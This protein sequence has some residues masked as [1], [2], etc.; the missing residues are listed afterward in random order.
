MRLV[1]NWPII[2]DVI[3]LIGEIIKIF[4]ATNEFMNVHMC[5][6][7]YRGVN[8]AVNCHRTLRG[9]FTLCDENISAVLKEQM[10]HAAFSPS[11]K[12]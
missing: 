4:N 5:S 3:L 1:S 6:S 10:L 7:D 12:Q 8:T 9:F 11:F 2:T